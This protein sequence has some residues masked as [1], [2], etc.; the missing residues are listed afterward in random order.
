MEK[1]PSFYL[2]LQRRL[3]ELS[4]KENKLRYKETKIILSNIKIPKQI[5]PVV[6]QELQRL[7][8]IKK[9]NSNVIEIINLKKASQIDDLSK[10]YHEKGIW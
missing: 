5:R 1:I 9:V 7:E 2:F 4:N 10:L 3:S 6:I 8:L